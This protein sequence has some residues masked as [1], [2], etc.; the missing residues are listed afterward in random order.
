[1]KRIL[2]TTLIFIFCFGAFASDRVKTSLNQ[3]WKFHLG[4]LEGEPWNP[5]FDDSSWDLVHLPH[6]LQLTSIALDNCLDDWTQP[7]FHR[8]YGWYRRV[9]HVPGNPH[10]KVFLEFEGAHQVTDLWV[11]GKHVGQHAVG[12]Y[13]P[14]HFDISDYVNR[15]EANLICLKVDNRKRADTPPDP[16]PFDYI[17]FSG[18]Y[19]DVYMVETHPVH[20]T[21][22]WEA[23]HAGIRITT[24]S[25]DPLNKNATIVV[26]T[27]VRNELDRPVECNM[28]TRIIDAE[29]WVVLTMEDPATIHPGN[30]YLF[31]QSSGLEENLHLW[32]CD[33][34]YLYRVR[35]EVVVDGNLVDVLENRMGVRK[36]ELNKHDGFVLNGKA[37][38]MIGLN[39]HQQYPYVGDAVPNS[40]HYK[41][42]LQLKELGF[43]SVRTA[44]YPQDNALLDACDELGILVYEE[45]PSWISVG[46]EAWFKNYNEATR[47]MVRNHRN[48]PSVVVWG[49]GINHRGQVP[50]AHY[51]VKQEDPTRWTASNNSEWTGL[52]GSG[53]CDIFSNMDYKGI[54]DWKQNEYLLA[55]EGGGGPSIVSRYKSD[56]LRIGLIS[57][58]AHAYYTFARNREGLS[59]RTRGGLM[60]IFRTPKWG[61]RGID[62]Y[63]SEA[64]KT[65]LVYFTEDWNEEV[66]DFTV[67]SNCEEVRL[68]VNDQVLA[69]RKPDQLPQY[70]GIDHPPF[71][72]RINHYEPGVL[73]AEGLVN[74]KVASS[75]QSQTPGEATSLKLVADLKGRQYVADGSDILMVYAH[76]MD[77]Q[78]TLVRKSSYAVEFSVS[79]PA[80]IVG[81]KSEINSNPMNS[82]EGIAPILLRAGT[83][84][85]DITLTAKCKG[86]KPATLKLSTLSFDPVLS[87][88]PPYHDPEILQVDLG[89][90]DHIIQFGW[91]AWTGEENGLSTRRFDQLGGF[92]ISLNSSSAEG[93]IRCMGEINVYGKNGFAIGDGVYV[94]D[95]DGLQ[96]SIEGLK[97]GSYRLRTWHYAPRA[98]SNDHDP[99]YEKWNELK[100]NEIPYAKRLLISVKNSSKEK[101][102]AG[103]RADTGTGN[104][105]S[106]SSP[107]IG[108]LE[109]YSDG[110]Q[111]VVISIAG[112]DGE[113]GIWLNCFE[114]GR[115]PDSMD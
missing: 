18:L 94:S 64:S 95:P 100:L 96:L 53:S 106:K 6:T 52:Q 37:M 43:N 76:V 32:S 47:R 71:T 48:H 72:F 104:D 81:D 9:L 98:S 28:V 89:G 58:T 19:R 107:G 7:T 114:L 105:L 41:D 34:P 21:F 67:Y 103:I 12:G 5:A 102:A 40:L 62:W 85:G 16:G 110:K 99:V 10:T 84:A 27:A 15:A 11:N 4:A 88:H 14:F 29:G 63:R 69:T 111:A 65:P 38:T 90:S 115:L 3:N 75:F 1:M 45:A 57:W 82:K 83:E 2:T 23:I 73:R 30:D 87:N 50:G 74:G 33:N 17:K 66:H 86:L 60:D 108:E 68:L 49:A 25:V 79:G 22:N 80:S 39:R 59:D 54:P 51:I 101:Q 112:M 8:D 91:E 13:T 35:S 78:G 44:H 31:N 92:S 55:M 93:K 36:I 70:A 46:N 109:F 42:I 113:E 77:E 20:I 24:P 97:E 56:P 26:E 61:Y